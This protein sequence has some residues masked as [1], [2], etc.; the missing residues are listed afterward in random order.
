MNNYQQYFLILKEL[1][2]EEGIYIIKKGRANLA[3]WALLV[4]ITVPILAIF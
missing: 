4:A 3:L 2:G 1:I